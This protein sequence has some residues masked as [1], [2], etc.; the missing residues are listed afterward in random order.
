MIVWGGLGSSSSY[1][2]TGA[3]YDPV[4]DSWTDTTLTGAPAGR[5]YHMAVWTGIQMIVLPHDVGPSESVNTVFDLFE[6]LINRFKTAIT[7]AG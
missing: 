1:L 2:Q 6:T 5:Y 3:L 4:N 7:K